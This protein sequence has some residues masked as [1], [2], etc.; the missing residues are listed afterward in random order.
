MAIPDTDAP[1]ASTSVSRALRAEYVTLAWNTVEAVLA[2]VSGV[3]ASSVALTAFGIDS[4][5]ELVSAVVVLVRLRAMLA[6]VEPD[7]HRERSALRSVAV[8]FYALATYVLIDATISLALRDRPAA[9]PTGIGVSI[10]ALVIMPTLAAVKRRIAGGL[11]TSG[12]PGAATLLRADAAETV[13][14]AVLAV[15]TLVGLG[16]DAAFGWWWADPV[17]SL[18]VVYF[19]VREGREAWAGELDCCNDD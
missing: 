15:T 4:G 7:E 2:L 12:L 6:R 16:L 17:A 5:I 13:L 1:P 18:A 9:S 8:C 19:A 3:V 11:S 14:C 10:A